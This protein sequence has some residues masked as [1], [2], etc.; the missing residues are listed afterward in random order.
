MMVMRIASTAHTR[1]PW[2]IHA[3]APDFRVEDVWAFR[4]PGA[5]PDDFPAV[6]ALL[7]RLGRASLPV[8][9]LFAARWKL[10]DLFGLDKPGAGLGIRISS[11]CDRLPA[12]L[13]ATADRYVPPSPF[14][15][16]YLLDSECAAELG[17]ETVHAIMHLG[18]VPARAGGYELR[19][20]VLVKPNGTLG[21]LY[22]AAIKP[23]RHLIVYPELIRRVERSL[24]DLSPARA[25][26]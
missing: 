23:F 4:A 26:R 19:M 11:L 16:V 18:W 2:R 21:H 12:D 5:G 8:R 14:T 25:T 24:T 20:A 15:S 1:Q 3:I 7:P 9:L 10:G 6:L 13:R 17:N 22:M